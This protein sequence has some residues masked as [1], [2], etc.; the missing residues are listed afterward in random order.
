[1]A[2][3]SALDALPCAA[4]H[5]GVSTPCT[6]QC[7]GYLATRACKGTGKGENAV[8]FAARGRLAKAA[9]RFAAVCVAL[10]RAVAPCEALP[11]ASPPPRKGRMLRAAARARALQPRSAP[12]AR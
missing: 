9:P 6:P 4:R 12:L 1:M 5:G 2:K 3:P 10:L 7:A 11:R 8:L